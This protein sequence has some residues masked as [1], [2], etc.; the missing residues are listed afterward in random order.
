[1]LY[2]DRKAERP[3]GIVTFEQKSKGKGHKYTYMVGS[4]DIIY[5][6]G[7]AFVGHLLPTF[8]LLPSACGH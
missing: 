6:S 2:L 3:L 1:M 7:F 8:A 5:D 4:Q